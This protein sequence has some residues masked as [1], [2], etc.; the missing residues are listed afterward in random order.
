MAF[1]MFLRFDCFT[2]ERP[3]IK[4]KLNV[5]NMNTSFYWH[6]YVIVAKRTYKVFLNKPHSKICNMIQY[7]PGFFLLQKFVSLLKFVIYSNSFCVHRVFYRSFLIFP[8][9]SASNALP[10][11]PKSFLRPTS[12]FFQT[13]CKVTSHW[14]RFAWRLSTKKTIV[15]YLRLV[16]NV[17]IW[18]L[19]QEQSFLFALKLLAYNILKRTWKCY[20]FIN[21][22]MGYL[23]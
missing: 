20:G 3:H 14:C 21:T 9:L 15:Y 22:T 23:N 12:Y 10:L 5:V 6:I 7:L 17:G 1:T 8:S 19:A 4:L 18:T 16:C 2:I 11:S 13:A